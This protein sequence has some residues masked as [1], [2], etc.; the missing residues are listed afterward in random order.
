M[1]DSATPT[2]AAPLPLVSRII[3]V[4]TSPMATFQNI[5]KRYP[6]PFSWFERYSMSR[7]N[8]VIA[9]GRTAAEVVAARG[10]DHGAG[11]NV[12][13]IPPGVD[14]TQFRR[15]SSAFSAVWFRKR[16]SIC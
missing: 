15:L 4:I 13:V 1:T 3:G 5:A 2:A 6:P 8:G 9:F 10:F 14:L 12:T 16:A 7:A 11:G